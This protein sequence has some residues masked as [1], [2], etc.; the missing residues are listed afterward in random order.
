MKHEYHCTQQYFFGVRNSGAIKP[1][2]YFPLLAAQKGSLGPS[3]Q[4]LLAGKQRGQGLQDERA[5]HQ[6][7]AQAEFHSMPLKVPPVTFDHH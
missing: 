4:L 2:S 1:A 7:F 3:E 6:L 5:Q